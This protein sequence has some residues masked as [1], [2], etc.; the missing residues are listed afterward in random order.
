MN[1]RTLIEKDDLMGYDFLTVVHH[2]VIHANHSLRPS[3]VEIK[4]NYGNLLKNIIG[5]KTS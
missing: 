2:Q 4:S 1:V 3:M 5:C